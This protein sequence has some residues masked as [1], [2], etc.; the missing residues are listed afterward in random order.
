MKQGVLAIN[1]SVASNVYIENS[2]T[3]AG[4]GVSAFR[5]ARA[6]ASRRVTASARCVLH[7]AIFDRGSQYN[8]E[9]A[10]NGRS[11]KIDTTRV[12]QWRQRE[13]QP[14]AQQNLLSQNEAQS[15]LGNKYTILTTTDGVNGRF[16]MPIQR[17]RLLM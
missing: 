9:V 1:G 11:D 10:G 12:S 5:A 16:E 2:G 13:R 7:D 8:V 6:A 3:L 4:E 17:I 15:L 14:G